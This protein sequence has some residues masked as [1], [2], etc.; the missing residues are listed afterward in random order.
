MCINAV[1]CPRNELLSLHR[2][3]DEMD[4]CVCVCVQFTWQFFRSERC[5]GYHGLGNG[6]GVRGWRQCNTD[7]HCSVA[8]LACV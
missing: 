4:A 8:R 7:A 5:V 6:D 3:A 1:K 2:D